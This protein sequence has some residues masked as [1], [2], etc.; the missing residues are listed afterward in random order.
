MPQTGSAMVRLRIMNQVSRYVRKIGWFLAGDIALILFLVAIGFALY[1][2]KM[3]SQPTKKGGAESQQQSQAHPTLRK[4]GEEWGTR[5][6]GF[7][8][9]KTYTLVAALL[10]TVPVGAREVAREA[11]QQA[12]Q[13]VAQPATQQQSGHILSA[14][15]HRSHHTTSVYN[16]SS[17]QYGH[18][19]GT[20][21]QRD[22]EIQVGNL[23]YE[24][25]QIHKEVQVGKDYPVN[26]E[27]DKNGVAKKLNVIVGEK[28]YTYRITGTRE[29]KS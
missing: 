13:P 16:S 8:T 1:A 29:A 20:S 15:T 21:V 27:T 17:G 23:I 24:S 12:A 25:S 7:D 28:R 19:G 9:M 11:A 6:G 14:E 22:T 3:R 26:I 2:M 4:D 18:G 5:H 10:L